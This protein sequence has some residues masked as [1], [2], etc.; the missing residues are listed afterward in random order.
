MSASPTMQRLTN[1]TIIVA[2][3]G[4]IGGGLTRRFAAEG[5]NVVLG[6]IDVEAAETLV[7]NI[8]ADGGSAI[9]TRLDGADEAST[10]AVV[11]LAYERF[12]G[13]DGIH[14]N[15]AN[16]IEQDD[17]GALELPLADFDETLRVNLRG[18]LL[19]T[20]AAVPALIKRGGGS[21]IYTSSPASGKGEPVRLAYAVAK[22]GVDA[23]MRHVASLWRDRH[24]GELHC[25]RN[26]PPRTG[27]G[28]AR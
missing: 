3:G 2:G 9:A 28:R 4:G 6:D 19:C 13:L 27:R 12:G 8:V 18:Y 24:S 15:F 14:A 17:S 25:P 1:K 5:A 11:A 22:A 23:L 16:F 7:K 21:I 10:L 20:R 26:D